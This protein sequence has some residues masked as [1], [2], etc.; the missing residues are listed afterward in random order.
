MN[1][2]HDSFDTGSSSGEQKAQRTVPWYL[3]NRPSDGSFQGYNGNTN[4]ETHLTSENSSP[5]G[6]YPKGDSPLPWSFSGYNGNNS[7]ATHLPRENISPIGAYPK[8]DSSFPESFRGYNGNNSTA[9]HLPRENISPIGDYPKGDSSFPESFRGTGSMQPD[10]DREIPM[11]E[12]DRYYDSNSYLVSD[13]PRP[14]GYDTFN[15]SEESSYGW[16]SDAGDTTDAQAQ[17]ENNAPQRTNSE[18][19]RGI[20]GQHSIS[21]PAMYLYSTWILLTVIFSVVLLF[22]GEGW[23]IIFELLQLTGLVYIFT[24][25]INDKKMRGVIIGIVMSCVYMLFLGKCRFSYPEFFEHHTKSFFADIFMFLFVL[26]GSI[27]SA[28]SHI[29]YNLLKERCTVN[30]KADII[31]VMTR[32]SNHKGGSISYCPLLKYSYRGAVYTAHEDRYTN[33]PMFR[34]GKKVNIL[35]DPESPSFIVVPR[36]HRSSVAGF[37]IF[38]ALFGSFGVA[39]MILSSLK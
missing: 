32:Q 7:T 38:G 29:E 3:K 16:D 19:I 34:K 2:D 15:S 18:R 35:I 4:T 8:G 31:D 27:I 24:I 17:Q 21:S 5:I 1:N 25:T 14:D 22:C 39:F 37:S 23:S 28:Y 9:T 13:A 10:S 6:A 26:T 11:T 30:L 20:M 36:M 12:H 33:S